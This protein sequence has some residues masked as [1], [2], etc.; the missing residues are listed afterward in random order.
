[1]VRMDRFVDC[2]LLRVGWKVDFNMFEV[3][4]SAAAAAIALLSRCGPRRRPRLPRRPLLQNLQ[5]GVGL[6][7]GY[8]TNTNRR[9][10]IILS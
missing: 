4:G 1:M 7:E 3:C 5:T 8:S 10:I 6:A 2:V 9:G